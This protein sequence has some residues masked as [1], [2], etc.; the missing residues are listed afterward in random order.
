MASD[1]PLTFNRIVDFHRGAVHIAHR[2]FSHIEALRGIT[3][4]STSKRLRSGCTAK[5]QGN[6]DKV[7]VVI[8]SK[9][10]VALERFIFAVQNMI[11]VEAFNKDTSVLG[12]MSSVVLGQYFRSFLVK[13]CMV[14]SQLGHLCLGGERLPLYD[15][16]F[17]IVLELRDD[18]APSLTH[19]KL[20]LV[21]QESEQ[22]LLLGKENDR[23]GKERE[24]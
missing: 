23:K 21:V 16:T 1:V 3:E 15:V 24:I 11:E 6:V 12:A 18:K 8:K 10:D 17:A 4:F 9:D 13:L 14:E 5:A 20:S 22:K 7:V 2:T 19:G